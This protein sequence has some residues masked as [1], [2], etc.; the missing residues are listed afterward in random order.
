MF[1]HLSQFFHLIIALLAV[2]VSVVA[3]FDASKLIAG[4]VPQLLYDYI[5]LPWLFGTWFGGSTLA[6]QHAFNC[7]DGKAIIMNF[8]WL[9]IG[10]WMMSQRCT[11]FYDDSILCNCENSMMLTGAHNSNSSGILINRKFMKFPHVHGSHLIIWP[12][13]IE[14]VAGWDERSHD[15]CLLELRIR[16]IWNFLDWKLRVSTC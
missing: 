12:T 10:Y 11:W 14:H 8:A 3:S 7:F 4:G 15:F 6:F 2:K 16:L 5:W 13:V 1:N 9:H